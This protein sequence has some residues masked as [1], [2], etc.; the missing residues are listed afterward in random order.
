RT[1]PNLA[2]G[3]VAPGAIASAIRAARDHEDL[4]ERLAVV[5]ADA[6]D[7]TFR[8]QIERAMF[9]A[10]IMGYAAAR[11]EAIGD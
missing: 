2:G 9:A 4:M 8:Q 10:E 1:L 6:D 3:P 5:L 7:R 11:R